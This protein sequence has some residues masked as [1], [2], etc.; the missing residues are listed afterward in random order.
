MKKLQVP[1]NLDENILEVYF[2][3]KDYINEIYFAPHPAV[4]PTARQFPA[5]DVE[6]YNKELCYVCSKSYY[7]GIETMLLL[8]GTSIFYTNDKLEEIS[9]L[10][11]MLTLCNLT[12][13]VVANPILAEFIHTNFPTLKIRLSVLSNEESIEKILQIDRLG[14]INEICL[15][16]NWLKD[17][18][19]L[20]ELKQLTKNLKYSV[21]VNSTCRLN[22]PLYGW[23]HMLFNSN[24][25]WE[26]YDFS[27][28]SDTFY[29]QTGK[30][31]HNIF[32]SPFLLP[33]ELVYFEDYIDY[34]K[35]EDRTMSTQKLSQVLFHYANRINPEFIM[36]CVHGSCVRGPYKQIKPTELDIKWR[37]YMRDCKGQC[38]KCNLCTKK[39]E[40]YINGRH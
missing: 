13:V 3:Y 20:K 29:N 12:G 22:C 11:Y 31:E 17:L 2:A 14:Y 15:N 19:G 18:N 7:Y 35:L 30:L 32:K 25:N 1:Y 37:K 27:L 8:N 33:E 9:N 36:D 40:E 34:F 21:I 26:T 6:E 5:K 10:I 28:I 4:F 39:M 38:Y 23:H 16:S 24:T